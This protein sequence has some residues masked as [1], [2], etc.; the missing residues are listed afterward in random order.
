[1]REYLVV[2]HKT[3]V[4]QHLIEFVQSAMERGPCHFHLLVP[5]QHPT[6]AWTDGQVEAAAEARLAE[7]LATFRSLGAAVDGEIGDANPVY[8]IET[9]MRGL[10]H[11]VDEIVMSTLQPHAS[12]WL[13]VDAVSR[14]QRQFRQPVTHL[15]ANPAP[16]RS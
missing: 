14:V 7:G 11:R 15:V 12:K 5:V 1:M 13:K 3:L 2:A 9:A 10:D 8:A 4:G 6:G 16:A